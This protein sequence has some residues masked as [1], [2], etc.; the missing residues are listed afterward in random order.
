MSTM[1]ELIADHQIRSFST[2]SVIMEQD[3]PAGPL[4]VLVEGEVE[5]LREDV[6]VAKTSLP[7]ACSVKCP[8]C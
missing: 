2:A 4:L 8:S 5:I 6:Q 1:L 3:S 7:G